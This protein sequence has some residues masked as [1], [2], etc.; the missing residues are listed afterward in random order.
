MT[1]PTPT[2]PQ[3]AVSAFLRGVERRA[4]LFA[5][6][7]SGSA[8][9]AA[10]AI[11]VVARVFAGDA[12][13]WPMARWPV[14]YWR[15]L[16]ATPQLRTLDGA[17]T[18]SLLPAI[19]RLPLATRTSVLLQLVSGLDDAAISEV[20][21]E[22]AA[23]WQG[24]IRDALP[25]DLAGQP[26]VAAWRGWQAQVKQALAMPLPVT[27]DVP[28]SPEAAVTAA[29]GTPHRVDATRHRHVPWLWIGVAGCV[30]AF[31]A[32]FFLHPVGRDVVQRWL[33]PIKREALPPAE[34]PAA[35]YDATDLRLHPDRD[36]LAAPAELALARALPLLAWLQATAPAGL[37]MAA[38]EVAPVAPGVVAPDTEMQRMR[39]WDRLPPRER[40]QRRGAWEAWRSLPAA[41]RVAL[42]AVAMRWRALPAEAQAELRT[43]FAAQSFDARMGWWLG[44]RIGADW[45]RVAALFGFVDAGERDAV[46][47]LLRTATP[48][49][50]EA[51]ARLAQS[52]PPEA[53]AELRRALLAQ[54]AATRGAWLLARVQG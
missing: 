25:A 6:V 51:L 14:Q 46:L 9:A 24:R 41:E 16:L 31:A 36:L 43:Q 40:G 48:D 17:R 4:R 30:A 12:G 19:A 1:G 45:P 18:T 11:S 2:P 8:E 32:A 29:P 21:G 38:G 3:D 33:S 23:T 53:R 15:L 34:A 20:L 7:Q 28:A 47:R 52:T 49:E 39:A 10:R 26:D 35:R 27:A 37:A 42:R 50:V 44:P 22:P 5:E 54:P 13:R